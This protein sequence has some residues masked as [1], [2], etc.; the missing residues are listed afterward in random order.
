MR[1]SAPLLRPEHLELEPL[2]DRNRDTAGVLSPEY[3]QRQTTVGIVVGQ[4]L[5]AGRCVVKG[6][7]LNEYAI[8][9]RGLPF[10]QYALL[11]G[12]ACSFCTKSGWNLTQ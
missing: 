7:G 1:P 11:I 3:L 10:E 12:P 5:P 6:H 4:D 8:V 9:P 2:V